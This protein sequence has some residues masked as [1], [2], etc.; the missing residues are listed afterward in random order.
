MIS[1]Y[2]L[3]TLIKEGKQPNRV[4]YKNIIYTWSGGNFYNN[5][6]H[7]FLNE[8]IAEV[9]M[10]DKDIEI[11]EEKPEKIEPLEYEIVKEENILDPLHPI[12]KYRCSF[13]SCIDKLEE[14]RQ[15]VNY[16]LEVDKHNV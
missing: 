5:Q 3:L 12:I 10:F 11:I 9:K 8:Y 2:E 15:A 1:Y 14:I 16:L 6:M 4:K 7:D 13:E